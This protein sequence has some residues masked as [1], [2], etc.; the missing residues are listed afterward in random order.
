MIRTETNYKYW[1][2]RYLEQYNASNNYVK[3]IGGKAA[4]EPMQYKKFVSVLNS[5]ANDQMK[6]KKLS[7]KQISGVNIAKQ[8][9]K[10]DVYER[11]EKQGLADVKSYLRS[12]EKRG[13]PTV[14]ISA[15]LINQFRS[16]ANSFYADMELRRTELADEDIE[17][18]E[19]M[20][21]NSNKRLK[22]EKYGKDAA[23][24]FIIS[25]EFYDSE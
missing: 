14:K 6:E 1:Y 13:M 10:Q 5:E 3:K 18:L 7:E 21:T 2:S 23:I 8:L 22:A 12:L 17:A 9:A 4:A 16:G 20:I 19:N 24:A 25:Q 11:T 15:R